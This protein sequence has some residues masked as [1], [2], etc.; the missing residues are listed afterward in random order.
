MSTGG[1]QPPQAGWARRTHK[2]AT[3]FRD[4]PSRARNLRG[5]CRCAAT[6]TG[7]PDRTGPLEGQQTDSG[8]LRPVWH[9]HPACRDEV[10]EPQEGER[11]SPE[12][13]EALRDRHSEGPAPGPVFAPDPA[14]PAGGA[15]AEAGASRREGTPGGES[16]PKGGTSPTAPSGGRGQR[17]SAEGKARKAGED[18]HGSGR[19]VRLNQRQ[20]GWVG[21]EAR[22]VPRKGNP[23]KGKSQERCRL[24][25]G[26]E[27]SGGTKRQEGRNPGDAA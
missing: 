12:N 7:Q 22:P 1:A 23:S 9:R 8:S 2:G 26:G 20:A 27:V 11:F 15:S 25:H 19:R 18:L 24:K 6:R 3:D 10:Q 5:G 4:T 21:R 14:K 16:K 17:T 13:L